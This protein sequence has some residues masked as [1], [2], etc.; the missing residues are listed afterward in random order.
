[1]RFLMR[2]SPPAGPSEQEVRAL[3]ALAMLKRAG[4][5]ATQQ[6]LALA[7]LFAGRHQHFS[8]ESLYEQLHCAGV[9]ISLATIYNALK[10]FVRTGLLRT[11]AGHGT[12]TLYDTNVSGHHHFYFSDNDTVSDIPHDALHID[13]PTPPP[14]YAI[15][16]MEIMIRLQPVNSDTSRETLKCLNIYAGV[17]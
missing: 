15:V 3:E 14:G 6:R 16:G 4:L 10:D 11:I 9:S 7:R 8:A 1:M 17:L 5:R 2:K 12:R 13:R